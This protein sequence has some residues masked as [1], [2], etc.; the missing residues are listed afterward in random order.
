MFALLVSSHNFV[1]VLYCRQSATGPQRT[2]Y[3]A[4][5]T[6]ARFQLGQ[7]VNLSFAYNQSTVLKT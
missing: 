4:G 3:G 7:T 6:A 1:A 2:D 5:G